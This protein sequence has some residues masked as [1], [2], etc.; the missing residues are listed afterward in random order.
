MIAGMERSGVIKL[1]QVKQK[2]IHF[3]AAITEG[4][5]A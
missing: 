4:G 2:R 1:E 5:A 3:P